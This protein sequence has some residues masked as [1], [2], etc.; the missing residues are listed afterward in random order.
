MTVPDR[1]QPSDLRM[2]R[3][4]NRDFAITAEIE[5][6][7][8]GVVGPLDL[9]GSGITFVAK[10]SL[11]DLDIDAEITRTV[12]NGISITDATGGKA[13][14]SL[15]PADTSGLPA[16]EMSVLPYSLEVV[17]LAGKT[18]EIAHGSLAVDPRAKT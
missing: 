16:D 2:A 15:I 7:D 13:L 14:L 10:R 11:S 18:Y 4:T 6:P 1:V 12:G 9:T 5:D 17:T 8:T 3:G